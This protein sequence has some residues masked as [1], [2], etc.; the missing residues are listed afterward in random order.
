MLPTTARQLAVNQHRSHLAGWAG[1][2]NISEIARE[3]EKASM[4]FPVRVVHELRKQAVAAARNV[5]PN[6]LRVNASH[7]GSQG[8][9]A[10]FL[11]QTWRSSFMSRVLDQVIPLIKAWSPETDVSALLAAETM[12]RAER[13]AFL[14]AN[15]NVRPF[16]T[17]WRSM[18]SAIRNDAADVLVLEGF[19]WDAEI[20]VERLKGVIPAGTPAHNLSVIAYGFDQTGVPRRDVHT[21]SVGGEDG[22]AALKRVYTLEGWGDRAGEVVLPV[23][24]LSVFEERNGL[25]RSAPVLSIPVVTDRLGNRH[26]LLDGAAA[27]AQIQ[28]G[29]VPSIRFSQSDAMHAALDEMGVFENV[30]SERPGM[31]KGYRRLGEKAVMYVVYDDSPVSGKFRTVCSWNAGQHAAEQMELTGW[32]DGPED[33]I[34]PHGREAIMEAFSQNYLAKFSTLAYGPAGGN[35]SFDSESTLVSEVCEKISASYARSGKSAPFS[36]QGMDVR[37]VPPDSE[38]NYLKVEVEVQTRVPFSPHQARVSLPDA[39]QDAL[40]ATLRRCN[41]QMYRLIALEVT[42]IALSPTAEQPAQAEPLPA[43]S[44]ASPSP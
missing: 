31:G 5:C 35:L 21:L 15:S 7:A 18:Y 12:P 24:A 10:Y 20:I 23:G 42:P 6:A 11:A 34:L 44:S 26:E 27:A 28:A 8:A 9:H 25:P 32:G 13:E 2:Q 17:G 22:G 40:E 3:A 19:S 37:I 16:H 38:G 36:I 43:E 14:D 41:I 39:L 33:V 29:G 1:R 30:S 4:L